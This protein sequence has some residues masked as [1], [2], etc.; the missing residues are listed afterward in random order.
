MSFSCKT[1]CESC[2]RTY[3]GNGRAAARICALAHNATL[4]VG[5]INR[6]LVILTTAVKRR[7]ERTNK[8]EFRQRRPALLHW[9]ATNA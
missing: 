5:T 3:K 8:R 2:S 1:G 7:T 6:D 9:K 4:E